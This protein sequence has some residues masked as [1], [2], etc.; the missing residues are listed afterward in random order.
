M[1]YNF[2]FLTESP[3]CD[4]FAQQSLAQSVL[5]DYLELVERARRESVDRHRCA[6]R[7]SHGDCRPFRSS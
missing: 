5:P 4:D 3:D 6:A 2:F 7:R 1:R